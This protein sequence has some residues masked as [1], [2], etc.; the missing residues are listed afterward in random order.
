MHKKAQLCMFVFF[1]HSVKKGRAWTHIHG[2]YYYVYFSQSLFK[3]QSAYL[4]TLGG[5]CLQ[6]QYLESQGSRPALT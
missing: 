4:A 3:C 5:L 1:C 6:V 2:D